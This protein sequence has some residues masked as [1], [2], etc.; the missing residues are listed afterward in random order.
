VK[1]HWSQYQRLLL[2]QKQF[3]RSQNDLT[4][5]QRQQL[6]QTLARQLAIEERILDTPEAQQIEV[7]DAMVAGSFEQVKSKYENEDDYRDM[8]EH[9]NL[10]E[11]SLKQALARQLRV[12]AV[13]ESVSSKVPRMS[14]EQ[15]RAYY[16][17]HPQQFAHPERRRVRQILVT[18]NEQFAEN[19]E[20][21]ALLR[22]SEMATKGKA[23]PEKF[24]QL[25]S[26]FSECP[27]A[28]NGG[29]LGDVPADTLYPE[30]D[31]VLFKM[32][33]GAVSP[34][35]RTEI[36]FHVLYCEK[37]L[38][39]GVKPVEEV[40]EN[41]IEQQHQWAKSQLQKQWIRW[42]FQQEKEEKVGE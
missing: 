5:E 2:A 35:I 23:S 4:D 15:A 40:I 24:A 31:K 1:C 19:S 25:A 41:V 17:D 22:A 33:E 36:G 12:N 11:A 10:D 6:D 16:M 42:L 30:L 38:Q 21:K 18:V 34:A 7:T 3:G 32:A 14:E 26:R 39:A 28:M 20:A 27:S 37:I 29:L 9:N 8:L 13:L